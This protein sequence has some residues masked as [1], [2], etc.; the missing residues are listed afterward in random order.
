MEPLEFRFSYHPEDGSNSLDAYDA[1]V[2]L[3][4]IARS[5]SITTHYAL[6]GKVIKQ[7]PALMGAK[8]LVL[9]PREGSFEFVA[10]IIDF[11]SSRREE[12]ALGLALGLAANYLCD[13]T[14]LLFRRATGQSEDVETDRVDALRREKPGEIDALADALEEDILRLHRPLSGP[15]QY[16]KIVGGRQTFG[17]FDRVTYDYA[18]TKTIGRFDEDF[19]GNVASFNANS[20]HGRFWL[21]DEGRTV[22]FNKDRDAV[23]SDQDCTP[24]IFP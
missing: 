6:H 22:S 12:I 3:Y 24:T 15:V 19:E 1:S 10:P 23:F 16:F 18:K 11:V 20:L 5:L 21:P 7:A 13:L 9:P 17:H 4:G 2:A 14:K 8:V